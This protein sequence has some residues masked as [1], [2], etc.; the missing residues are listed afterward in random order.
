[1]QQLDGVT[2]VTAATTEVFV[3]NIATNSARDIPDI[4][5]LPEWREELP[6]ALVGGGPSLADHLDELKRY[7]NI[8]LC[9]SVHDYA[10]E[11]GV[12]PKWSVC[13]DPDPVAAAYYSKPQKGCTYLIA[14]AC[15]DAVFKALDGYRVVRWHSG[16]HDNSPTVWGE[17]RKVLIGGGCTVG[18]RAFVIA[19]CFGFSNLHFFGFDGCLRG[20]RHHAYGYA[21]S[22]ESPLGELSEVRLGSPD[23]PAYVMA[24]Y[25]MGQLFDFQ[26]L[27][28]IHGNR[29]T[30]TVHGGG[31]LDDLVQF[32]KAKKNGEE[33]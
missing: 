16:G 21:S 3:R 20:G 7:E 22:D 19:V 9:G 14:S 8:M 23:G 17:S 6:I 12:E 4:H 5:D 2:V 11:N 27:L 28:A 29:V 31:P 1:M 26:K 10:V 25:M 33:I 15:D 24:G 30:C 13:C 32:A 18:T